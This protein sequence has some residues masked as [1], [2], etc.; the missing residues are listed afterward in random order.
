MQKDYLISIYKQFQYY[1]ILGERTF[2]QLED[3]NLFWQFND[4]SNSIAIIVN[5]LWGNM[6]SRWTDFLNTDGEKEWRQRDLEFENV[7]QSKNE[8]IEKWEDGWQCLFTALESINENNFDT[9]IYIRNQGHT[10]VEAINRQ[11]AHYAYHVGQIVFIGRMIK[12]EGWESLSIPK[13]QSAAFNQEKFSKEKKKAHFTDE[14]LKE[15][16]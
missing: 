16:E 9:V 4:A 1:K 2:N 5:H 14:I 12:G 3:D 11:L 7:I 10:I 6:K 8:L 15:G 13:G